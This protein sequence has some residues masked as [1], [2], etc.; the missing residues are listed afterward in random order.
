[1][2]LCD[3]FEGS[4]DHAQRE[5]GRALF[6][7]RALAEYR[8][9]PTQLDAEID[10]D[11]YCA[12]QLELDARVLRMTCEC[13]QA[14]AGQG[15]PHLWCALCAADDYGDLQKA[16]SRSVRQQATIG[17]VRAAPAPAPPARPQI[18]PPA[19]KPAP[20]PA[21]SGDDPIYEYGEEED[22][23]SYRT[24]RSGLHRLSGTAG[25]FG[26]TPHTPARPANTPLAK[27][28]RRPTPAS[29]RETDSETNLR[30]LYLIPMAACRTTG[31]L[32]LCTFWQQRKETGWAPPRPLRYEPFSPF[33]GMDDDH[34]FDMLAP[35]W[36]SQDSDRESSPANQ[37][38][39]FTPGPDV[40]PHL[41]PMLAET[42]R[43]FWC[44]DE[45]DRDWKPLRLDTGAP[46]QFHLTFELSN[47]QALVT[48]S[49][50]RG[51]EERDI[52]QPLFFDPGGILVD[53]THIAALEHFGAFNQLLR[54]RY[55][56]PLRLSL[57]EADAIVRQL[58]LTS[59][60]DLSGLPPELQYK[61]AEATVTGQLF[62]RTAQYK[63]RGK[64]QL[65]VDLSFSY[66]G[67]AV[68]EHSEETQLLQIENHQILQR[69]PSAEEALRNRMRL[70]DFRLAENAAHE[71]IGWK[72]APG[73]LD[74]VV[75]ELLEEDWLIV[76]EGKT[77]RKPVEKR[78]EVRSGQ[79]WFALKAEV[80][81][82]DQ[83][84]PLPQLLAL[85]RKGA[86]TVVLDDGTIGVLPLE[87]LTQFTVL[88]E[89]GE[90]TEDAL[91][92]RRS[93]AVLID[94]LIKDRENLDLDATFAEVR[95]RLTDFSGVSPA[96]APPG[97]EGTLRPYQSLGLGWINALSEIGIGGC[98]ADDMGL[99]KT[100]QV[101]AFLLQRKRDGTRKPS[102]V[103]MPKSLIFNWQA[104]AANF[105]PELHLQAHTGAGRARRLA[106]L[107][108]A[109][110]ILT[111]YGTLRADIEWLCKVP[112]DCCI[113]DESQAIKNADTSSAKAA[114]LIQ[115]DFR[116]AMS[117][118]PIENHIRE[119]FSQFEFL[120]P[121]ML[122]SSGLATYLTRS[123]ELSPEDLETIRRALHP[124]ILR[125]TK[126][127]VATELPPKTEQ[128]IYCALSPEQEA[129]YTELKEYYR[130]ELL[131]Q[132]QDGK[133]TGGRNKID[134]LTALL[135]LRQAA[136]HPGMIND[137][138]LSIPSGKLELVVGRIQ[139][140]I[141]ENHKV[142]IFSQFTSFLGLVRSR[143]AAAGIGF[144]YL[145]GKTPDRAEQ[146]RQ[147]QE[148]PELPVFLISLKA[149]GVGLN[150]TA[151]EYVFLLDP[152]W[153]PAVEAQAV[154]RAYRIGQT[155]HVFA[156]RFISKDTVEEKVLSM[157]I[158]KKGIADAIIS[159]N[160][161]FI[162]NISHQDLEFLLQ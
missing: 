125:R 23:R 81:F 126:E 55:R 158:E 102:L 148:S 82:G 50:R 40:T 116:L 29:S 93:Q 98:L 119:L 49:L 5:R 1:M 129:L 92:F 118:T 79:D 105:A 155:R 21:S 160:T 27:P 133:K 139:E 31:R 25:F 76:A 91:R 97:F 130:Q 141:E 106:A 22:P 15:C 90:L 120:N 47:R 137:K 159:A 153:N 73:R 32:T 101:L 78:A 33:P 86:T 142:L 61:P 63:F 112:F 4:F 36:I 122:G 6:E 34:F 104:E 85:R 121:G 117:G 67:I 62:V 46:W 144:C 74:A 89:I 162:T 54:L 20:P 45:R 103:V 9:S 154:D 10:G 77:Y 135:R 28:Q 150:L 138:H 66:G 108:H 44:A 56:N 43:L 124:Y 131:K 60:V 100:I 84:I 109:D 161:S 58:L 37:G 16:N 72:L 8:A 156:Y 143:L 128:I 87:W 39:L 96:P 95:R 52:G 99:G 18:P 57:A 75:R 30:I 127:E 83:Q 132:K 13:D 42:G 157:Q 136:C 38:N 110:V 11:P 134:M 123:G 26:D 70:L 2:S 24:P 88:T 107:E 64:E 149:G 146:V 19:P 94:L 14:R 51:A 53:D 151:A 3:K 12:V 111:T 7:A 113:L 65:H 147:F 71:E 48:G 152:W 80:D 17:P 145:D 114:R 35:F 69:D 41:L 59:Q 140:L 115:A 68:E